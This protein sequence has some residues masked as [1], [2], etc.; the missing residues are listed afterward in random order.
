MIAIVSVYKCY[1]EGI[2]ATAIYMVATTQS[3]IYG[4]CYRNKMIA[5]ASIYKCYMEIIIAIAINMDAIIAI[6]I[7]LVTMLHS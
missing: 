4:N 6:A 7:K 3:R 5:I 2:I 1:M